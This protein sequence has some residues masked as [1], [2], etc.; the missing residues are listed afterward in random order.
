MPQQAPLSAGQILSLLLINALGALP[1]CAIGMWIGW[2]VSGQAAPEYVHWLRGGYDA[3]GIG[4]RTARADDPDL[5]DIPVVW[6]IVW[7]A[8]ATFVAVIIISL[9]LD[10]AGFFEWAALHVARWG[11]GNGK[12]LFALLVL[13]GAAVAAV[14]ANDGAALILTPIVIAM[15]LGA[16]SNLLYVV[17]AHFPGDIR[18][19]VAVI[20]GENLSGGFLGAAA[21]AWSTSRA[22]RSSSRRA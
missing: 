9:L 10:K 15:L 11:K 18:A 14:F 7:N 17:L 12:R 21:I 5:A 13:L 8:T 2:L 19:F 1:F 22:P 3:I 6:G 16:V 20:G 4:G